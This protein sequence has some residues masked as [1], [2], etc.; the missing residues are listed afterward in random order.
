MLRQIDLKDSRL[1][2]VESIALSKMIDKRE[3]YVEQGRSREAHGAGMAI[4]IFWSTLIDGKPY[5]TGWDGI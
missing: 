2:E 4:W 3:Q 5:T 1:T